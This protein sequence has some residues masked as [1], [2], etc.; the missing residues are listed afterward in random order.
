MTTK[1]PLQKARARIAELEHF[2]S[3][4]EDA[5]RRLI[6]T[7]RERDAWRDARIADPEAEA[8]AGCVRAI[9]KMHNDIGARARNTNFGASQWHY[10]SCSDRPSALASP[11]GRILLSLIARYGLEIEAVAPPPSPPPPEGDR[12]VMVP[13]YLADSVESMIRNGAR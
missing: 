4:F 5:E 11:V 6:E 2:E 7:R 8:L 3:E 9:E 10:P 13:A 1:T 12:L